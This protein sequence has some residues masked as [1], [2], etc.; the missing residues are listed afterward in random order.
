MSISKPVES[1][2]VDGSAVGSPG[3]TTSGTP[4]QRRQAVDGP[5]GGPSLLFTFVPPGGLT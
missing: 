3:D 4:S 1:R 2:A 5:P